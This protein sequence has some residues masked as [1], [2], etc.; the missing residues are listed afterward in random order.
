MLADYMRESIEDPNAV[1]ASGYQGD[2]M[3]NTF[4]KSLTAKQ[5]AALVQYLVD[6]QKGS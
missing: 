2:V 3:P 4:G 5:L 6:G 1:L